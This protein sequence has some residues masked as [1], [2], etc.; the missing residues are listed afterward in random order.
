MC[1]PRNDAGSASILRSQWPPMV[2][3]RSSRRG[4]R[5]SS[6]A[7]ARAAS[8]R[9][10]A[11]LSA[12]ASCCAR[13]DVRGDA[14]VAEIVPSVVAHARH[15]QRDGD[16]AG[17][18]WSRGPCRPSPCGVLTSQAGRRRVRPRV[19]FV[20]IVNGIG[21]RPAD[22]LGGAPAEHAL[23]ARVEIGD[24]PVGIAGDDQVAGRRPEH[25]VELRRAGSS[26][27][28]SCADWARCDQ[29][30]DDRAGQ[31]RNG[32]GQGGVVRSSP[33]IALPASSGAITPGDDAGDGDPDLRASCR[34]TPARPPR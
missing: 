15:R 32:A 19:R 27:R 5:P 2:T 1:V 10:R 6:G 16:R 11:A 14:H 28:T 34:R 9:P 23:G 3:H 8:G 24:P 21:H 4:R 25:G 7:G 20:R 26:A 33:A 18:P 29:R 30:T 31:Q 12:S 13:G 22:D 17:R